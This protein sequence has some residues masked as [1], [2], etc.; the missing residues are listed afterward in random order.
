MLKWLVV[1]VRRAFGGIRAANG[2]ST[3]ATELPQEGIAPDLTG[4][5][6]QMISEATEV[7]DDDEQQHRE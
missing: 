6:V 1:V 2:D 4:L 3:R 7:S 5:K